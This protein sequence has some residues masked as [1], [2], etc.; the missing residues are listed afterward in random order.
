MKADFSWKQT[1]GEYL[2]AY[3]MAKQLNLER[4]LT[5]NVDGW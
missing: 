4:K 5:T 3:A 1:I 2:K